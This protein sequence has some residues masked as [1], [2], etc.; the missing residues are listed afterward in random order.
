[1]SEGRVSKKRSRG[2][3]G[4]VLA[5]VVVVFI[6]MFVVPA[7]LQGRCGAQQIKESVALRSACT[8]MIQRRLAGQDM[9]R[10]VAELFYDG[11][12]DLRLIEGCTVTDY[13]RVRIGKYSIRQIAARRMSLG[14]LNAEIARVYPTP[15]AWE[16]I[17]PLTMCLD[18]RAYETVDSSRIVGWMRGSHGGRNPWTNT[19]FA[20]QHVT[21]ESGRAEQH[22]IE[23]LERS[24]AYYESIGIPMPEEMVK[25]LREAMGGK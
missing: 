11:T 22:V 13:A 2:W 3:L 15:I 9:P 6:G 14:E 8:S 17:G 7:V 5:L 10:S 4:C 20:D 18:A 23:N 12:I 19:A 21:C 25:E 24:L 1:M 16:K